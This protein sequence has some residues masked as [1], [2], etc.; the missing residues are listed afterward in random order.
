MK[1]LFVLF[2]GV[3]ACLQ[4]YAQQSA[5]PDN[6]LTQI[7]N[8]GADCGGLVNV[9]SGYFTEY[10]DRATSGK[11]VVFNIL[12]KND[13]YDKTI[14]VKSAQNSF[15]TARYTSQFNE[16]NVSA[17]YLGKVGTDYDRFRVVDQRVTSNDGI[18]AFRVT[19]NG[20]A[21]TCS[22]VQVSVKAE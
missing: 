13:A 11:V 17:V 8:K 1:N 2:F 20:K 22:A 21:S 10:S 19:M 18:F 15:E 3:F 14:E 7:Q 9:E 16:Q 4:S 12:V 6:T 5:F